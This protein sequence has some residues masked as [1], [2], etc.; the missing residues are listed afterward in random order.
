[1][2]AFRHSVRLRLVLWSAAV[3]ALAL[4]GFSAGVFTFVRTSLLRR[5]DAELGLIFDTAARDLLREPEE[6]GEFESPGGTVVIC[7]RDAAGREYASKGW[8]EAGL[9]ALVPPEAPSKRVV[10]AKSSRGGH[11][12]VMSG[13]RSEGG[14]TVSLAVAQ[15]VDGV[16]RSL[17]TL[18]VTLLLATPLVLVLASLGGWF[19]AG[20]LLAPVGAMAT[21]AARITADDLAQRLPVGNPGDEFGR[22][23]TVFNDT[24]ARLEA[25]FAQLRRFASDASHELRTPLSAMRSVGE[26]ALGADGATRREAVA[27]MLEE[28]DRLARLVDQLLMLTRADSGQIA[29]AM[30]DTDLGA[31]AREVGELLRVLADEKGQELL[32]EAGVGVNVRADRATLRLAVINL[33][34]NAIKYT[35][36]G[37]RITLR[38]A[39]T[40]PNGAVLE[41]ADSGPGIAPGDRERVFE[42]FYRVDADRSR[43]TGGAGLGLSIARWAV[44]AN[45]GRL[46]VACGPDQGSTFRI[47]LPAS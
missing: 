22:L 36:D 30:E 15:N 20:R 23:A 3:L 26:A 17:E 9:G 34:D 29:V 6:V 7:G 39:S 16:Y 38:A 44:E 13:T 47:F 19:L 4:V 46:T 35:P 42:R 27:S 41:V 18:A 33:L 1:M 37:G 45:G 28:V 21:R 31:L 5:T 40:A 12:R 25:S 32:V 11:V 2:T 8:T 24:L 43:E 14:S 10:M